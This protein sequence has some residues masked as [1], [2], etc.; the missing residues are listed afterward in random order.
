[1]VVVGSALEPS[2]VSCDGFDVGISIVQHCPGV[3]E[4]SVAVCLAVSLG[5]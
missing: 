3:T 1:V 4:A 2:P 5:V